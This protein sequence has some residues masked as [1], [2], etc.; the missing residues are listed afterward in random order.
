MRISLSSGA[1]AKSVW[2]SAV[3][4]IS[5][6]GAG[7]ATSLGVVQ[8][9]LAA[10]TSIDLRP[11]AG[12]LREITVGMLAGAAGSSLV[13]V[14]DG[15]HAIQIVTVAQSGAG[16]TFITGNSTVGPRLQN[17]DATNAA[18]YEYAGIDWTF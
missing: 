18:Q 14:F 15:T 10:S 1:V 9:S 16:G 5:N 4:T 2:N 7:L 8:T 17:N 13:Q 12:K 6:F 11:S 3:R